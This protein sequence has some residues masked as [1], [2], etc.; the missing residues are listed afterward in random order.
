LAGGG[1][2]SFRSLTIPSLRKGSG[3]QAEGGKREEN[4][5]KELREGEEKGKNSES[6]EW[7]GKRECGTIVEFHA[8]SSQPHSQGDLTVK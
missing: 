2:R 5:R 6:F 4:E 7:G 3:G 1:L 8:P